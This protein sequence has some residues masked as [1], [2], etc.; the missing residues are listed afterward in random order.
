[1][2][3]R[4]GPRLNSNPDLRDL[5]W[6]D[7]AADRPYFG[8]CGKLGESKG[9]FSLLA[10]MDRLKR[11]GLDVGLVALA[12][13]QPEVEKEFR[14]RA[15]KLGLTDR[16]LQ[17][18]FL[19]HWRVPEFLRACFAVCCLEQDFPIR[20]HTPIIAREVLLCGTCLV[21]STEV[22]RK[23]PAHGRLPHGYGC[24]AIEDVNDVDRLSDTLAAIVRHP[25]PAAAV[26]ARGREFA[27]ELQQDVAFPAAAGGHF[28]SG[29]RT[30]AGLVDEPAFGR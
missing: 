18:P 11:A 9:S 7:L 25:A 6:G 27:S 26:G 13:G 16:V 23:L 20:F 15:Q 29:G 14:A 22:I 28:G 4:C 1:M 8:I 30:R 21:G 24:V 19:P 5:L 10:A 3:R 17:I 2:S 12:H